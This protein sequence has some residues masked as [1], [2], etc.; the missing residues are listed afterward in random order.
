MTVTYCL[1]AFVTLISTV[2]SIPIDTQEATDMVSH[3]L[4]FSYLTSRTLLIWY[5]SCFRH[6][7]LHTESCWYGKAH[8]SIFISG[9]HKANDMVSHR[10]LS[11][12]L[13]H[14]KLLIWYGKAHAFILIFD[15]Q[16]ATD[17]VRLM[18]LSSYL[19]HRQRLIW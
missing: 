3:R 13:A 1:L 10:L 7:F 9:T 12:Y 8:A 5:V 14:R 18:H 19:T 2:C 4:S 16:K 11:W 15:T 17:M 6:T